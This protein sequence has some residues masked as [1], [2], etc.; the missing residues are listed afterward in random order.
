MLLASLSKVKAMRLTKNSRQTWYYTI[1]AK[2]E[3]KTN[4]HNKRLFSHNASSMLRQNTMPLL[5]C[6]DV[7]SLTILQK[8][9]I[10][11]RKETKT[12]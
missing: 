1:Q 7:E 3:R 10:E 2:A 9:T 6:D 8:K 11:Q 4:K 12:D 5:C